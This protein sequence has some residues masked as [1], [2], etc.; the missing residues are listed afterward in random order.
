MAIDA[1]EV[2]PALHSASA[3]EVAAIEAHAIPGHQR[4][5]ED[6]L[7]REPAGLR[8][9]DFMILEAFGQIQWGGRALSLA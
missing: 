6:P 8:F 9:H 5:Q 2:E 4:D 7:Q 3:C 1:V